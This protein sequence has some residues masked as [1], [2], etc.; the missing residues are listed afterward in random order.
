M[1]TLKIFS[2]Q[3]S[4]FDSSLY[5]SLAVL[6]LGAISLVVPSRYSLGALMLFLG[7]AVLLI[8]RPALRLVRQDW[9][10][11]TVLAVYAVV[12]F[13]EAWW[14]GQ[15]SSGLDKPSRFLLAVPAMLL[16]LAYPPRLSWVWGGIAL[17]ATG[18]RAGPEVHYPPLTNYSS[19]S[20]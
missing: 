12:G 19:V 16:M 3:A 7:S 1:N 10:I 20:T 14:D 18:A 17:G 2:P 13:L 6:L 8:N 5:T 15:G 4:S 9:L 11:I